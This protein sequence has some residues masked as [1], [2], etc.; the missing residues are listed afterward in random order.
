MDV[1]FYLSEASFWTPDHA[2]EPLSH[3]PFSPIAYW[4]VDV[5][6]PSQ[7][8]Q[9]GGREPGVY[10]S[11]CEAVRRLN[12]DARCLAIEPSTAAGSG[13]AFLEASLRRVREAHDRSYGT[14]SKLLR[15]DPDEI[16]DAIEDGSI[17]LFHA[18]TPADVEHLLVDFKLWRPKLSDRAVILLPKTCIQG[19]TL[20]SYA[21]FHDLS[22]NHPAFEFTHGE[23]LGLIAVGRE[24]PDRLNPLFEAHKF[25][26][27]RNAIR[28]VYARLGKSLG[29]SLA[30]SAG[31]G[32][33]F[34]R[35]AILDLG[36]FEAEGRRPE[37]WRSE[38]AA[39]EENLAL[40]E[41]LDMLR[42]E[43]AGLDENHQDIAREHADLGRENPWLRR[44]LAHF[45]HHYA[46]AMAQLDELRRS[47]ALRLIERCRGTRDRFFPRTRLHGRC[48][49]LSIRFLRVAASDGPRPALARVSRRVIRKVK[50]TLGIGVE[51]LSQVVP[52]G[53]PALAP[54]RFDELPWQ[55]VETRKRDVETRTRATFKVLLVSHS[56]CRTGA[57]LCLLRLAEELSR[58]PD[59]ECWVVL[60][61]SGELAPEFE[62][63]AP[64]LELAKTVECGLATWSDAPK[65]IAARFREYARNG[66]AV[67][68]TMAVS[69]FHEALAAHDVPVLSWIHELPT[70]IE[71]LGGVEAI[72][73]IKAASRRMI[74]P[75][76][77]VRSAL[78]T[79]FD[80]DPDAIQTVR[81][82]LEGKTRDLSRDEMRERVRTELRLPED[83]RIVLGCGTI[84]LRKG[85]DLFVQAARR[86]LSDPEA[87]GLAERTWFVWFGHVVNTD[88]FHWL[89]HDIEASG[90]TDR[91]RFAGVR[92]GMAPYFLAAD[93]FALTSRE[94]PCP[95][96]NLEAMESALPVV[97]FQ[98]SGG[99]PEVLNGGGVAV[100][101]LDVSAMAQAMRALLADDARRLEMGRRGRDTI[102]RSFTWPR[103]MDEFVAI[104]KAQYGYGPAQEL[105]VS[106]IV[107]NYR[108]APYLEERLRSVF[109]QTVRPHE[110]IFLDDAS[111][112]DSVEVARRLAPLSP[113]PMRIV[114]NDRNS[115]STFRQWMKGMELATGDLIWLA[116]SDDACH[117]QFLE[118][119]LPEF[120]DRDVVLAY[121]QSALIGPKS[122][123]WAADFLA[124]T[125]DLDPQ[126]WR[127]R[128]TAEAAEEAELGL[129]QKNTI[130]N[131]S[132][133]VFR[134]PERLDFAAE[135]AGMRFAGDWLFYAMML[136]GGKIAFVPESL[137]SY[138]R[139]EQSVS[140]QSIKAD[141]HAEETL[142]VKFRIFETFDVSL[143]AMARSLGQTL[144]EYDMMTERFDLKRAALMS[145]ARAAAPLARIRELMRRRLGVQAELKVL[146]VV[147]GSE[148]GLAATSTIHLANALAR[149]HQVFICCA[150]P[151]D[152]NE[153]FRSQ[154]NDRVVLLEGTLGNTPWSSPRPMGVEPA[155]RARATILQELI[156]FHEIDV[157]HSRH[158]RA[159]RL[160]AQIN[161]DLNLPWFVHLAEGRGGW[162]EERPAGGNA[163]SSRPV[164]MVS[165]VFYE[166]VASPALA[167]ESPELSRKR[168]IPLFPGMQ[169]DAVVESRTPPIARRDAEFLVFLIAGG[170]ETQGDCADA[171]S[172]VRVLNRLP[173]AERGGRRV[174]LVLT[175]SA[176]V[177]LHGQGG[178]TANRVALTSSDPRDSMAVLAQCDA[179][180]APHE[181]LAAETSSY[182]AAAL[183]CH[184]PIIAPDRGPIHDVLT[185][186]R[187]TAGLAA[188]SNEHGS[189]E[190][191]RMVTAM[192][193]Y[194]RHPDLY[195]AHRARARSLFEARFHIDQTAAVCTEAYFHARDFLVFPRE[196][197]PTLALPER[198]MKASRESA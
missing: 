86:L 103:F 8:V 2:F 6:R 132:A 136:R 15:I 67:C 178:S 75:A 39:E 166:G 26:G 9:L 142:H 30:S 64:T 45:Q 38:F 62:R 128:Y 116:E 184:L 31:R 154:L 1:S 22:R 160:V 52:A 121:A 23:G 37:T 111:P 134:K 32:E 10:F 138:R 65:V 165:G 145:N 168:W 24:I 146:L 28:A 18:S 148:T 109:E 56:A 20:G 100:P 40:R 68:N 163:G 46:E 12:L 11:L 14:I 110:I 81:Y 152:E 101:Y 48:L 143:D 113:V 174:R 87:S 53:I 120:H 77:V 155:S 27:R 118:R 74:V 149:E 42:E 197:R 182:I 192:L 127:S 7:I 17:D 41:E 4:L 88:L 176:S 84:D 78:I 60:K 73:R 164:D 191:D 170:S 123:A 102:R 133:V 115:G 35:E 71:I 49:E 183:A 106:V 47:T 135:L 130:P 137:N 72:D 122:E 126:R 180:L 194:L 83:A 95:F 117:P 59:V 167:E 147:D 90:F 16:V 196:T 188:P 89:R 33:N 66:V 96:A 141:T 44:D 153:G 158:E 186:D 107:P 157:I 124:H 5:L 172:A 94:D 43:L 131:A 119:L 156:R 57:P 195:A 150:S 173:A 82:G 139:H 85:A 189:L 34:D 185:L 58:L 112:D 79:R 69:E 162:F 55:G 193:R 91:I 76:D 29:E 190:V 54:A 140:F 61:T 159:D 151:A 181:N 92:G 36:V 187:R 177:A 51:T 104:L 25:P 97:A 144:F 108:H 80:V 175:G 125:D 171:M 169:P 63:H 50:K 179:A 3:S 13:A 98:G 114:V 105:K 129:S 99:A 93:L 21:S 161:G 70:F 19:R 198:S